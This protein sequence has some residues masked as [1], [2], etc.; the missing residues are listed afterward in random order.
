[1]NKH[2]VILG[3]A[4]FLLS[5]PVLANTITDMNRANGVENKIV[6]EYQEDITGNGKKDKIVIKGVPYDETSLYLKEITLQVETD[7]SQTFSVQL[8][9]GYDPFA[10]FQDMNHDGVM[11]VFTSVATGGSGGIYNYYLYSFKDNQQFNLTVPKP[12]MIQAQFLDNYKATVTIPETKQSYT[13]DLKER[14]KEYDRLGLYINGKLN[15]PTELMVDPY[16]F[17]KPQEFGDKGY[18]LKAIQAISGAYHADRIGQ[19]ESD[20]YYKDGKWNLMSASF[21]PS[22]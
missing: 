10:D 20:W 6:K 19:V 4:F 13:I 15:E 14:K 7:Q 12:L 18:G 1:M 16:S 2:L 21:I 17:M 3:F 11:D 8:E 9:G 22:K 5:L